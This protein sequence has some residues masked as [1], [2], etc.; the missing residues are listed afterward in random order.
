L[1]AGAA[2]NADMEEKPKYDD[3]AVSATDIGA[4]NFSRVM[5]A[6]H[7]ASGE[8]FALKVMEKAKVKRLAVRHKNVN[9][10]IMM[11]KQTLLRLRGH[12]NVVSLFHTFS[13][14]TALYF[15]FE[16]VDGGELWAQLMDGT[17]Q[18]GCD[19]DVARFY[20]LQLLAAMEHMHSH[21]VVHR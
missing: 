17:A 13:D 20:L 15:L 2:V 16:M 9:N 18:I 5:R 4:G 6:R 3:F 11:E 12:R 7:R 1:V 19:V 8:V 10:E 14:D 21:G